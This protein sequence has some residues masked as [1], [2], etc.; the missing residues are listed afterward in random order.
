MHQRSVDDKEETSYAPLVFF[1]RNVVNADES[2]P[3][4]N[5]GNYRIRVLKKL[6]HV[7]IEELRHGETKPNF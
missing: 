4:S 6:P 3:P 1:S 5:L 7:A 2:A